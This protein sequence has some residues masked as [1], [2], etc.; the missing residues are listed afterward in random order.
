MATHA[1]V[2]DR[3]LRYQNLALGFRGE[4]AIR[5]HRALLDCAMR[6]DAAA[7]RDLLAAHILGGVD[8]AL[9]SGAL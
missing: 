1:A 8:A 5:E 9:A 2:F 6:R 7:A 3:Y 4:I